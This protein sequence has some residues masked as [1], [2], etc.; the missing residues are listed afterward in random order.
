MA[1]HDATA[2]E[3]TKAGFSVET[4]YESRPVAVIYEDVPFLDSADHDV[5]KDPRDI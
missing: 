5:L 4:V 3:Q 1:V 2:L